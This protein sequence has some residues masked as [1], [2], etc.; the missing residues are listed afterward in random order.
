VFTDGTTTKKSLVQKGEEEPSFA[1]SFLLLLVVYPSYITVDTV[2][3][4]CR[5]KQRV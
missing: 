4:K 5:S 3:R 1:F 2:N